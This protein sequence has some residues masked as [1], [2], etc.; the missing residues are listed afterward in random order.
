[1]K[2]TTTNVII[3]AR[4]YSDVKSALDKFYRESLITVELTRNDG[5]Y[6]FPALLAL[7]NLVVVALVLDQLLRVLEPE[8]YTS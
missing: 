5:T 1:M 4:S 6:L 8:T 2:K 7:V 3:T